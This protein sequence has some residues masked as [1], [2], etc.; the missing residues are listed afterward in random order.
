MEASPRRRADVLKR[1]IFDTGRVDLSEGGEG[2]WEG[3][4]LYMEI[5]VLCTPEHVVLLLFCSCQDSSFHS[6][7]LTAFS[8]LPV[9]KFSGFSYSSSPVA[10]DS[11]E[12]LLTHFNTV[13]RSPG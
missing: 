10:L 12:Y 1:A 7:S 6:T 5:L 3:H 4:H 13:S 8:Y 9:Y 2:S 11:L